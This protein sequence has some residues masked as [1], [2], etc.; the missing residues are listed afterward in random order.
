MLNLHHAHESFYDPAL[1]ACN[2]DYNC[3]SVNHEIGKLSLGLYFRLSCH[4]TRYVKIVFKYYK[5]KPNHF[6][7]FLKL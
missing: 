7:F 2:I 1:T 6:I 4:C 3:I 5:N